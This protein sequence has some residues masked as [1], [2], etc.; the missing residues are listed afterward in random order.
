MECAVH[1]I[2]VHWEELN[3]MHYLKIDVLR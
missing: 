1:L 2:Y 3:N